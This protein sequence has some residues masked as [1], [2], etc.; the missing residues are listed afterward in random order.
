MTT[1]MAIWETDQG[2]RRSHVKSP[3]SYHVGAREDSGSD[4]GSRFEDHTKG[5]HDSNFT[6]N[7]T[8][9]IPAATWW[10]PA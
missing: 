2:G 9:S 10:L 6:E 5:P 3:R 8:N 7:S 4:K 1:L